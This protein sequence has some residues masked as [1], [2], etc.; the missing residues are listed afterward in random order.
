MK[1]YEQIK[2]IFCDVDD[3][4]LEFDGNIQSHCLEQEKRKKNRPFA[5]TGSEV[6]TIMIYY[7]LGSFRISNLTIYTMSKLICGINFL[8]PFL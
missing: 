2:E 4:C 6:I 3:I 5:M 1:M 7:Q 8:R